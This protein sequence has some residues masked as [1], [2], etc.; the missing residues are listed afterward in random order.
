M[1]GDGNRLFPVFHCRFDGRNGDWCTENSTI[2]NRTNRSVGALPHFMELVF[3]HT[4]MIRRNGRTLHSHTIL[5]RCLSRVNSNLV[6]CLVTLR[7]TE[8]VVFCF[9]IHE[10]ENQLVLNHFPED[11]GHLVTIHLYQWSGHLNFLCIHFL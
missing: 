1:T 7:K 3:V 5:L 8:V 6:A 4:L 9:Q 11:S 10:R 2:E